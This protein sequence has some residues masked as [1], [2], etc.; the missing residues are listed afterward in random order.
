MK[1]IDGLIELTWL[2]HRTVRIKL[3]LKSTAF[4]TINNLKINT[5]GCKKWSKSQALSTVTARSGKPRC[6]LQ[7]GAWLS[8]NPCLWPAEHKP[9]LLSLPPNRIDSVL[10]SVIIRWPDCCCCIL[11][12]VLNCSC[13]VIAFFK[14]LK[15]LDNAFKVKLAYGA[16]CPRPATHSNEPITAWSCS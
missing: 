2:T 6:G 9:L 13:S 8:G 11:L 4:K 16:A 15:C 1:S 14:H 10:F 12:F 5:Y 7:T 3:N